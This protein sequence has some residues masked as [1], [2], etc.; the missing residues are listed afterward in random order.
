MQRSHVTLIFWLLI[1]LQF[2]GQNLDARSRRV[3]GTIVDP[4]GRPAATA[5]VSAWVITKANIVGNVMW[6]DA[7]KHGRFQLL[8]TPGR[9]QLRAKDLKELFP[10]PSYTLGRDPSIHF[11]E[12]DVQSS[13]VHNVIVKLGQ[14]GAL[15]RGDVMTPDG[16]PIARSRVTLI[17]VRNSY[18]KI[19]LTTNTSGQFEFVVPATKMLIEA[20]AEGFAATKYNDGKPIDPPVGE[21]LVIHIQLTPT[22]ME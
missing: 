15:L 21:S 3:D 5:S 6:V 9:Y 2:L 10:D 8:L 12:I 22:K 13:D 14:R 1:P 19:I 7:D 20:K 18:A 17:D 16:V 11:T 4:E